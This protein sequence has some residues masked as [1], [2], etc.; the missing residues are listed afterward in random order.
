MSIRLSMLIFVRSSGRAELCRDWACAAG[1]A[2]RSRRPRTPRILSRMLA[3]PSTL[4]SCAQACLRAP[5]VQVSDRE[6]EFVSRQK[7][8]GDQSLTRQEGERT[9]L[10]WPSRWRTSQSGPVRPRLL[11]R[12]LLGAGAR[13]YN[14]HA[15]VWT[16]RTKQH[17]QRMA[18][19]PCVFH[20]TGMNL[21][22]RV[23]EKSAADGRR[24]VSSM[25]R[26][27]WP[28]SAEWTTSILIRN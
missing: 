22:A 23:C 2:N 12:A 1:L 10:E 11:A 14:E 20:R 28:D 5:L 15:I 21:A 13:C 19:L 6:R 9:I 27:V 3:W 17:P 8:V 24:T 16:K 26:A 18:S 25:R 7:T 4:G